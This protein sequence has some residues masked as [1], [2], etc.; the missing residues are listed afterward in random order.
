M[1]I[2]A[3]LDITP[4]QWESNRYHIQTK[5]LRQ[6]HAKHICT[7]PGDYDATIADFTLIAAAPEMLEVMILCLRLKNDVDSW[8]HCNFVSIIEKATGKTWDEIRRLSDDDYNTK[9]L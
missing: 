3:Q 8:E 5:V 6:D 7:A 9:S 2:I 4:G 1:S